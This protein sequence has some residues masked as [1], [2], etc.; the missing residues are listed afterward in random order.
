MWLTKLNVPAFVSLGNTAHTLTWHFFVV[1]LGERN[2]TDMALTCP[3]PVLLSNHTGCRLMPHTSSRCSQELGHLNKKLR[4]H[5]LDWHKNR[6][7]HCYLC[8]CCFWGRLHRHPKDS[9]Q[10]Q[11]SAAQQRQFWT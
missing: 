9:Y 2:P 10:A 5:A 7:P 11:P 6:M 4:K 1:Q 8:F 3:L